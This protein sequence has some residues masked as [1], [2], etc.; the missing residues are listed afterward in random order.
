MTAAWLPYTQTSSATDELAGFRHTFALVSNDEALASKTWKMLAPLI[1][2]RRSARLW[3]AETEQF[4]GVS[5]LEAALPAVAAAVP[6]YNR[7]GRTKML[8]LDL[9]ARTHGVSAVDADYKRIAGWLN[10]CG[11]RWITDVSTSGGVHILVPLQTT[12]TVNDIRPLLHALAAK[13]PSLDK[14]PMLND[15][16]GCISVPGSRCR[17]GGFRVL[18]GDLQAAIAVFTARNTPD[19]LAQLAA[20]VG[21]NVAQA[22]HISTDAHTAAPE[23]GPLPGHLLR[24]DPIPQPVLDFATN[25]DLPEDNRW[26]S[27]SEARL[28][29]LVHVMWR[30]GC[31]SD[32]RRLIMPG[33]PWLGLARAYQTKP[34]SNERGHR[35]DTDRLLQRDWATAHRWHQ[36]RSRYLQ[37]VTHKEKHTRP[38]HPPPGHRHWLAHA[39]QWCDT[40][41][42][43]SP[44]RW[45]VAAVLQ[46]VAISAVRNVG[47]GAGE[48]RVAV[49]G[50]SLSLAAGLLSEST[51]WA[52]L[53]LLRD[54]D[55]SPIR[56]VV[57]G[58]GTEA[59]TYALVTPDVVDPD[60]DAV[61]RPA[62]DVVHDAW[63]VVGWQH[64]RVY[65]TI[66][67]HGIQGIADI[68]NN[69]RVSISSAYDTVAELCRVGLLTR[70]RGWVRPGETT[71]DDI[72]A[73][74]GLGGS[75]C[76]RVALYRAARQRWR[77]WL[78]DRPLKAALAAQH[79]NA[80]RSM[81]TLV[82]VVLS[83]ADYTDYLTAVVMQGPPAGRTECG[84]GDHDGISEA[85]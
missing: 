32:I 76:M 54:L 83:A 24:H 81:H 11:G 36:E 60:P 22:A 51:V 55:G 9:D 38:P 71:L 15:R 77:Q 74:H 14:T 19:V 43:S 13:C 31:L 50:R 58:V 3:S 42:R 21:A 62:V 78:A 26:V 39:I 1:A 23:N 6:L 75:R 66:A 46:A 25:G 85:A 59:D 82:D 67:Q 18:A 30:G 73:Q 40:R 8:A 48:L 70:G 56:L 35:P 52:V 28:S 10:E 33:Q 61:G 79:R 27:R 4:R 57:K 41:F 37:T 12:V 68:A 47:R 63:S 2:A 53:R 20:L 84:V 72:A 17:E 16:T 69:A 65:E 44:Q 80:G 5:R 29:V 45:S 49:G 64:R 7:F 34:P